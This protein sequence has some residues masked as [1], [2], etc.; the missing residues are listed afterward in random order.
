MLLQSDFPPTNR[1]HTQEVKNEFLVRETSRRWRAHGNRLRAVCASHITSAT[2][3]LCRAT[4]GALKCAPL[5]ESESAPTLFLKSS[6]I[7]YLQRKISLFP[8]ACK[9]KSRQGGFLHSSC[10]NLNDPWIGVEIY[11]PNDA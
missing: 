3:P 5:V 9:P 2:N 11:R 4:D 10:S 7:T 8:F 1:V 6:E